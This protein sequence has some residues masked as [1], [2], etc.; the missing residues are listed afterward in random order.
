MRKKF[1]SALVFLLDRFVGREVIGQEACPLML[2][3]TLLAPGRGE[4][5]F[6]VLVHYFPAEVSDRDPHD[7]PRSFLTFVL[8]G[9]YRDESW[10]PLG[11]ELEEKH[12]IRLSHRLVPPEGM[13]KLEHVRAGAVKFRAAEHL[14]IV[15]TD[16][17]GCWTLVM[18]GPLKRDW[19]FVR[20]GRVPLRGVWLPW[21]QYVKDFG[22]V[23]RCDAPPVPFE[24]VPMPL[25]E[26]IDGEEA[27]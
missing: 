22:G 4:P 9:R 23:I 6:K 27:P 25:V 16:R 14:H 7:H 12:G 2:R 11:N 18:M 21:K 3:W 17:V 1:R 26:L 8:R 5:W 20:V 10:H 24:D 15:E 19:G 13:R